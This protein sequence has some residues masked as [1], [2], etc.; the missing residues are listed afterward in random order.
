MS[1]ETEGCAMSYR[2]GYDAGYT[3]GHEDGYN[4]AKASSPRDWTP[5]ADGNKLP[6]FGKTVL[7]TAEFDS[8]N[9]LIFQA[10]RMWTLFGSW[11][12]RYTNDN[13]CWQKVLAWQPLPDPYNPDHIREATKKVD[14][15]D[16]SQWPDWKKRA[17]LGNYELGKED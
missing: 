11:Y 16:V 17:A 15:D 2:A 4:A 14:P 12:W 9:R 3:K 1:Y 13:R 6:K 5:C 10:Y 8:G 7:I